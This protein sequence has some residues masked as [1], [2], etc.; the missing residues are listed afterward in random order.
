MNKKTLFSYIK[1]IKK[2]I[3]D[4]DSGAVLN[5]IMQ[6]PDVFSSETIQINKSVKKEVLQTTLQAI[7]HINKSRKKEGNVL[8][9]E[10]KNYINTIFKISKQL[11]LLE[12]K[13]I[14][15]KKSKIYNQIKT[16][17][18]EY[19][20]SRLESEMIYYFER[21]DITEE[22]IRLQYHCRFFLEVMKTEQVVGKKLNF[23]SQEILREIN[24]IG[25]KANNFEIQ[26]KV[27]IMKEQIDKTKEQLQNIL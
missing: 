21:N 12:S 18:I 11:V 13:R 6:L 15:L 24:T 10:I 1:S 27:V 2:I 7:R 9:K 22:R 23:I 5:A 20:P 25:S 19:S 14:K 26:K 17:K 4:I 3:P 16:E 8:M